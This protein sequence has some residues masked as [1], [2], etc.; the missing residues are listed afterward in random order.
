MD[1]RKSSLQSNSCQTHCIEQT[2][3]CIDNAKQLPVDV[4]IPV[5]GIPENTQVSMFRHWSSV[6]VGAET[7]TEEPENE[8]AGESLRDGDYGSTFASS[9]RIGSGI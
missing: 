3:L 6:P 8:R 2:V 5:S 7:R 4:S 1:G 9:S